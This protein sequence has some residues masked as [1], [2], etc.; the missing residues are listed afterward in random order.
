MSTTTIKRGFMNLSWNN[1]TGRTPQRCTGTCGHG[2][3]G[4]SGD[5]PMCLPCALARAK[6]A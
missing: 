2:T 3:T 1:D 6:T 4:M 5:K